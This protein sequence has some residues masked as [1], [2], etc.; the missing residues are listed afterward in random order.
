MSAEQFKHEEESH[1]LPIEESADELYEMAPCGYLTTTIEGRIVKVNK[2]L[3]EWLGY[4]REELLGKKRFVDLLTVG[5]RMFYETHFNLLLRMQRSVDEIALDIICKDGR[6]LPTLINARQKRNG[7]GDPIL[8]RFTVFNSSERRMYERELLAARDLLQTTLASIGDGVIA[9]DTE[10]RITFLN[11]VAEGLSG[12]SNDAAAGKGIDEVLVLRQEHTSEPVESPIKGA[13]KDGVIVGLT[14][15]TVLISKNGRVIPIDDSAAPIRGADGHIVGAIIVFRDISAQRNSQNDLHEAHEKLKTSAAELA[16]S[17]E[18][19]SQFAHVASHDLRSPLNTVM[20]FA[21]LLEQRYGEQLN[22]GKELLGFLVG[23]AKRMAGLIE[24]LLIYAKVSG[25][26]VQSLTPIDANAQLKTAL[27][28]LHASVEESWAVITQDPLPIA[29]ID[30]THL[31]QIFQNLV[32][33]AIHYHGN[34]APRIHVSAIDDGGFWRFSCKDNG[35]GI[36][37]PYQTQ[38]FEPFK[39]LHGHDRP[40]SGIGLA[41]CRKVVERYKGRIWVE[42]EPGKGSTFYFTIPKATHAEDELKSLA[43]EGLSSRD[44]V[45]AI[46][47]YREESAGTS[48]SV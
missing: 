18:D 24:D 20:Q 46:P 4:E 40:G 28:N 8:N 37:P 48:K 26:A 36:E 39:R 43:L 2:T 27:E 25:A 16:R 13:L 19:L 15:H 30:P 22:E 17:N 3:T 32:G 44:A 6:V 35:I 21:Q 29:A 34:E 9:T 10:E 7:A 23:A 31:V 41:V 47:G 45:A 5:G 1:R 14:N 38:I 33:N 12:W 11:P 42:S